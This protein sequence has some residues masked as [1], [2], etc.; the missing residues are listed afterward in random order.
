MKRKKG[1]I[2]EFTEDGWKT[3]YKGKIV[4]VSYSSYY[5]YGSK[6]GKANCSENQVRDIVKK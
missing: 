4:S 2:I 3:F 1:D 6:Y 5:V